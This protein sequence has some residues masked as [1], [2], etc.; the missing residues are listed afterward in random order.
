M[1]TT[2]RLADLEHRQFMR[3][4]AAFRQT[5]AAVDRARDERSTDAA[6]RADVEARA[7]EAERTATPE[8]REQVQ[9]LLDGLELLGRP[10]ATPTELARALALLEPLIV[11]RGS[12]PYAIVGAMRR[13]VAGWLRD[14]DQ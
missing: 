14:D 6:Y 10:T 7:A 2:R 4:L 12:P 5:K 13:L 1:T 8:R 9:R 3:A 11:P